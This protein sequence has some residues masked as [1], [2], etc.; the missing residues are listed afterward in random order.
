M[1]TKGKRKHSVGSQG[2]FDCESRLLKIK[3][4]GAVG[5]WCAREKDLFIPY[6]VLKHNWIS[7]HCAHSQLITKELVPKC[8]LL[9][10]APNTYP[11]KFTAVKN[12]STC[13]LNPRFC[14]NVHHTI[15]CNCWKEHSSSPL[16]WL[17]RVLRYPWQI[18]VGI[19]IQQ[20]LGS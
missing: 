11:A 15:T 1:Y 12:G 13:I 19:N 3:K 17:S 20:F 7:W 18:W 6:A 14:L 8:S 10:A 9:S 5:E 4:L 16:P 2:N